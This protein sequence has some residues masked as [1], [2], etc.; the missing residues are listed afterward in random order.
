MSFIWPTPRERIEQA[1]PGTV[2]PAAGTAAPAAGV[3]SEPAPTAPGGLT[4][5]NAR[6]ALN[7]AHADGR[8]APRSDV[9]AKLMAPRRGPPTSAARPAA[10][11]APT[12]GGDP[13]DWMA[14]NSAM[15]RS[16]AELAHNPAALKT[17]VDQ[18]VL[19]TTPGGAGAPAPDLATGG[20]P[21]V[22]SGT[23][24]WVEDSVA[25]AKAKDRMTNTTQKDGPEAPAG[26]SGGPTPSGAAP[27]SAGDMATLMAQNMA[28]NMQMQQ[29]LAQQGREAALAA[30]H[31][32]F[33]NDLNDA[34][35]STIKNSG[36]S[37]K[38]A[39]Q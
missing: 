3:R 5:L 6:A 28:Q 31:L 9:I 14:Q 8:L 35:V 29:A 23:S 17:R 7:G 22:A 34:L 11:P 18:P 26:A 30:A 32:K 25:K 36:S 10:P 16:S 21:I 4:G 33:L 27:A 13:N 2:A 15:Q 20:N 39:A 24:S 19:G 38:A 1:A 37:I 12:A